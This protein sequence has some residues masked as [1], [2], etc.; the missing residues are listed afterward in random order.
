MNMNDADRF[1]WVASHLGELETGMSSAK[2]VYVND[3]GYTNVVHVDYAENNLD[4]NDDAKILRKLID[5]A[6]AAG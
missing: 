4:M 2:M 5:K 3:K 6:I 1:V